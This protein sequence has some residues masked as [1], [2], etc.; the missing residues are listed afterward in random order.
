MD[1]ATKAK[2]LALLEED[3]KRRLAAGAAAGHKVEDHQPAEYL[4]PTGWTFG[5]TCGQHSGKR[6][7]RSST[8]HV[9]FAAHVKKL[10]LPRFFACGSTGYGFPV[11]QDGPAKGLTWN[12]AYARGIS[13]NGDDK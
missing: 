11:Y 9:W 8:R 5:C 4:T 1:K 12:E 13:I 6:S 7:A 2:I 3:E 10:G